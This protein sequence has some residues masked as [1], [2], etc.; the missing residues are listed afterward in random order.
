MRQHCHVAESRVWDNLPA[1]R[2]NPAE[3]GPQ[4]SELI[5]CCHRIGD[6]RVKATEIDK[7]D[8]Q[9]GNRIMADSPKIFGKDQ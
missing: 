3:R 7:D 8:A 9:I 4:L 5:D 1:I 2:D 6:E